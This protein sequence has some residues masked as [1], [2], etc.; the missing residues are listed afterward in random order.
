MKMIKTCDHVTAREKYRRRNW[1]ME[2]V[3]EKYL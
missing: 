2:K 3:I 1:I